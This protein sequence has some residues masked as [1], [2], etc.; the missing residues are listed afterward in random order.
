MSY[1]IVSRKYA[2]KE[3]VNHQEL[4]GSKEYYQLQV[5]KKQNYK[6]KDIHRY[7]TGCSLRRY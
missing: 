5:N 3:K 1:I 4:T 2:D 6:N 7:I